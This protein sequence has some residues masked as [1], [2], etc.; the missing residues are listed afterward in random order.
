MVKT[1]IDIFYQNFNGIRSKLSE[2]RREQLTTD[3]DIICGTE[4]KIQEDVNDAEICPTGSQF[5]IQR[6][7]R[8]LSSTGLQGGGGCMALTRV[9][10]FV[11]RMTQFE[12]LETNEDLWLQIALEGGYKLLLCIIYLRPNSSI[13]ELREFTDSVTAVKN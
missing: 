5:S 9:Q 3:D 13:V 7:D 8:N 10:M 6:R 2:I 12:V 1:K 4:S 11:K